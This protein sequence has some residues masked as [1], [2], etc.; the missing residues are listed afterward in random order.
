M[1]KGST[2]NQLF[3]LMALSLSSFSSY[4]THYINFPLPSHH[5]KAKKKLREQNSKTFWEHLTHD[6]YDFLTA[7]L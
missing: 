5:K 6:N 7:A 4:S 2:S 1:V 3:H